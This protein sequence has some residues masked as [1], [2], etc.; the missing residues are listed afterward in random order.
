[1]KTINIHDAK[2]HLSS[3]LAE[4]ETKGETYLICRHGA[5]VAE[6]TPHR[7]RQRVTRHPVMSRIKIHYDPIE[8]LTA[9]EWP[10]EDA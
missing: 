4:I 3:V 10:M 8:P 1:M 6:L 9:A 7:K 2:T 5:P